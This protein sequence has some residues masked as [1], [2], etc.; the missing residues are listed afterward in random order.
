M[1]LQSM[2]K[3]GTGI[4]GSPGGEGRR[5][6]GQASLTSAKHVFQRAGEALAEDRGS[7]ASPHMVAHNRL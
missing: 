4:L 2:A 7:I 6:K 5:S 1:S 3:K